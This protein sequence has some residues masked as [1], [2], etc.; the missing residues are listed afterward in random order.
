MCSSGGV[1]WFDEFRVFGKHSG[2]K[3]TSLGEGCVC[4]GTAEMSVGVGKQLTEARLC[5][6]GT[7]GLV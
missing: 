7:R 5:N 4:K 2:F 1:L 6:K 3:M